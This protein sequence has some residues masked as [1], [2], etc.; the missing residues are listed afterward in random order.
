MSNQILEL[1]Q[2]FG[3]LVKLTSIKHRIRKT[4]AWR[5]L[6][7]GMPR[8]SFKSRALLQIDYEPKQFK[9]SKKLRAASKKLKIQLSDILEG[10]AS[11]PSG[12]FKQA[13]HD[14]LDLKSD[15][16]ASTDVFWDQ[17]EVDNVK[18]LYVSGSNGKRSV[19]EVTIS[20]GMAAG[21]RR[22]D[23]LDIYDLLF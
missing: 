22:Q 16:S 9:S 17:S 7:V 12:S 6:H 20:T 2:I 1:P 21:E 23:E 11:V 5:P 18:M 3:H 19:Q 14:D 13:C 15:D 10:P 8:K 4:S